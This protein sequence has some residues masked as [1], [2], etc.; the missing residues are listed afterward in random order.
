M[1][2]SIL[3]AAAFDV[4]H[5]FLSSLSR[6]LKRIS[7]TLRNYVE[8]RY[9][10]EDIMLFTIMSGLI[11]LLP[12]FGREVQSL[13]FGPEDLEL[14]LLAVFVAREKEVESKINTRLETPIFL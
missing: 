6:T 13:Y 4:S 12:S 5:C 1:N 7:R 3:F 11:L 8:K 2:I 10:D 9:L 14:S